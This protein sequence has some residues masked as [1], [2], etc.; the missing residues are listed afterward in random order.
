MKDILEVKDD[1]IQA[2]KFLHQTKKYKNIEFHKFK[3]KEKG[4]WRT[5]W[6]LDSVDSQRLISPSSLDRR[7]Y[8]ME[9]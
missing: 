6:Y 1:Y 3:L 5:Y 9:K 4:T 2:I 7:L 8:R